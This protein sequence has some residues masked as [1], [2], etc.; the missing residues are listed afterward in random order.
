MGLSNVELKINQNGPQVTGQVYLVI[1]NG[2]LIN[3]IMK[4]C[5]FWKLHLTNKGN[6]WD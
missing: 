5:L 1:K 6:F 3:Q 4:N 2:G